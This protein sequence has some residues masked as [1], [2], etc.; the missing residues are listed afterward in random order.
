MDTHTATFLIVVLVFCVFVFGLAALTAPVDPA[1]I[2]L[3]E[4]LDKVA[5]DVE[6]LRVIPETGEFAR[7]IRAFAMEPLS[8]ARTEDLIVRMVK[9][10]RVH[11]SIDIM[12]AAHQLA[13]AAKIGEELF[14]PQE[15][16]AMYPP[17]NPYLGNDDDTN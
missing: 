1:L 6:R 16:A 4:K 11:E 9:R 10:G 13:K 15:I 7:E 2:V 17:P 8:N 5:R 3:R 14:S 12:R